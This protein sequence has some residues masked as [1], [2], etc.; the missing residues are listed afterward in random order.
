MLAFSLNFHLTPN[1][2]CRF[3]SGF[4]IFSVFWFLCNTG[5]FPLFFG[6]IFFACFWKPPLPPPPTP[7]SPFHMHHQTFWLRWNKLSLLIMHKADNAEYNESRITC[8]AFFFFL[9]VLF[10]SFASSLPTSYLG[11]DFLFLEA[12][13]LSSSSKWRAFSLN[14]GAS[15][16]N[17]LSLPI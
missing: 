15:R 17:S 9:T 3:F 2:I 13:K 1:H 7:P 4:W 10:S 5:F 16:F 14:R 12:F 6:K 11:F 8:F